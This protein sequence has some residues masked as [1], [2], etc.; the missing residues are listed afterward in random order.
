MTAGGHWKKDPEREIILRFYLV[1]LMYA[2]HA[3]Q[4]GLRQYLPFE[5]K[6]ITVHRFEKTKKRGNQGQ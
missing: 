5:I 6:N 2:I 1:C 3:R 4:N